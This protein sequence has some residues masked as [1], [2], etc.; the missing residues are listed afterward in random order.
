MDT[1]TI[2]RSARSR[3]W[4][5]LRRD[6]VAWVGAVIIFF[7]LLVAIAGP[8]LLGEAESGDISV[9][10]L[11]PPSGMHPLGTDDLGRSTL[12]LL[13]WGVRTSLTVGLASALST[14]LLGLA[15][16]AATGFFGG[17]LDT[18]VMRVSEVF[19]VMPT[20][21]LAAV[22]VALA[23]PGTLHL[24]VVIVLLSWPQAAR[25]ARG[26]V[27]RVRSLEYVDAV[28]CLGQSQWRILWGEVLPNAAAPVLALGTL[29][30]DQA[31]LLEAGLSF[32]GLSTP[33]VP[34]WGGMLNEGQRFVYQ[35]WWL[36]VFPGLAILVTVL[37]F[38]LLGDSLGAAFNPRSEVN[39]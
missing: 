38:N 17:W 12:S 1:S 16:G 8:T 13:V 14:T 29:V 30:I 21:V 31:I 9:D 15:I 34:S 33:D 20:F 11:S 5:R 3:A 10:I 19:Q 4:W 22:V 2:N 7:L 36:S 18:V 26:E 35:A 32:F 23:G 37:S 25:L 39:T 6:P 24:I 27:L 28:R